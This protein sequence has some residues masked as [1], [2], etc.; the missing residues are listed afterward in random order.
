MSV[1]VTVMVEDSSPQTLVQSL[2]LRPGEW[3]QV[4]SLSCSSKMDSSGDVS[5]HASF[6]EDLR[7]RILSG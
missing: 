1:R 7:S 2:G 4:L 3:G 5:G 6:H